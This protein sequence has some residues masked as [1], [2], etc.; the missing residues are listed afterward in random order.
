MFASASNRQLPMLCSL[1]PHE[2][3]W[4]V[5]ALIFLGEG[6]VCVLRIPTSRSNSSHTSEA[7]GGRDLLV[8][9]GCSLLAVQTLVPEAGA[10]SS[11]AA[12]QA[13]SSAGSS[14]SA[15]DGRSSS[16]PPVSV[17]NCLAPIR[18]TFLKEGFS[19]EAALMASQGRRPSTLNLYDRRLRLFG[20]WCV[21]RSLCPSEVSLGQVA[22]FF[23]SSV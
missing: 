12:I 21:D 8:S 6:R 5:N 18:E 4:R 2:S 10:V 14:L 19:E 1:Q 15:R 16:E 23:T 11:G 20:E 22:D 3:V 17:F 7:G 13:S 9:P